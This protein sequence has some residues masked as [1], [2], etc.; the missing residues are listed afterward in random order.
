MEVVNRND[1]PSFITKD[2]SEI[3]EILAPRNSSI[4]NQS[5]AEAR[6]APGQITDEHYHVRAEEVY[7][8]LEGRGIMS[9]DGEEREVGPGDGIAILPG[10]RHRAR[11]TGDSDLVILCCCCP[12]YEHDDTLM[13]E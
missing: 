5:L 12:A 7:Y 6:V 11:N 2:G 3:R 1:V 8:V 9:I 13:T 10:M 4:E